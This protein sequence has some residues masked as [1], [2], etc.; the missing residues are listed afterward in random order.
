[1]V[2]RD[3]RV[4]LRRQ[5]QRQQVVVIGIATNRLRQCRRLYHLGQPPHFGEQALARGVG[6]GKDCVE[7]RAAEHVGEFGQQGRAADQA[8]DAIAHLRKQRMRRAVPQEPGDQDVGVNYRPHAA[9][10]LRGPL[11]PRR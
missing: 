4:G 2:A 3:D 5:G 8:D 9:A 10:A 1:V 7:L 11:L 6:A